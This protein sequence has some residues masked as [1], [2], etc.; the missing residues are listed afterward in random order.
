[1]LKLLS[2]LYI[3]RAFALIASGFVLLGASAL[4]CHASDLYNKGGAALAPSNTGLYV[5]VGTGYAV[6]DTNVAGDV[7]LASK[8]IVAD[9]RA[10]YDW[11]AGNV[12]LG[13]YGGAG[14]DDIHTSTV[15][16]LKQRWHWNA[17]AR[18]GY[19]FHPVI[20]YALAGWRSS[21]FK[22]D[23]N[24]IVNTNSLQG[25]EYGGGLEFP[26]GDHVT[27]GLELTRVNYGSWAPTQ[28]I[29]LD[30]SDYAG[31]VRLNYRF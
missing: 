27:L 23:N 8:G 29:K 7:S 14:F 18:L 1:M 15:V 31:T 19:D 4:T 22:I 5:S 13:I 2:D 3:R 16:G 20:A 28:G 26:A 25:F 11:H 12:V 24:L 21:D 6:A 10:G 9:L 17:G 30:S